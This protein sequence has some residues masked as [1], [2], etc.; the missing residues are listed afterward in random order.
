[1]NLELFFRIWL[2]AGVA[3]VTTMLLI[4]VRDL[5]KARKARG[6]QIRRIAELQEKYGVDWQNHLDD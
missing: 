2:Y 5:I 4:L 6:S 1:M 3:C